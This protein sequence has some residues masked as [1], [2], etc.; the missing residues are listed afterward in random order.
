MKITLAAAALAAILPLAATAG[1][2]KVESAKPATETADALEA[3]AQTAGATVFARVDHAKGASSVGT[4]LPP[5]ELVIFG[6][7]ALGTPA[8]LDDPLAGI[9]LPMRV[10]VYEDADGTVWLAYEDPADMFDGLSIAADADY[11]AKM[12]GALEK[13]TGAAATGG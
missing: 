4:E 11:L 1:I 5:A 3:A 7:P 13:L 9:F 10:L 12:R 8:M 6:N 2:I